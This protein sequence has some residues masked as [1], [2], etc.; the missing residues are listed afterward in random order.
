[1]NKITYHQEGDYLIPDIIIGETTKN[2]N[3]GRFGHLKL[4]YIKEFK[5]GLYT[6]LKIKGTLSKYLYDIDKD[7]N[8]RLKNI[9]NDLAKKENITEEL[10]Q[11]DPLNWVQSMNNIKNRAEEIVLNEFIYV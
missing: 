9:I 7:S 8:D 3:L 11:S 4:N 10:K 1:M 2:E 5:K 6:S